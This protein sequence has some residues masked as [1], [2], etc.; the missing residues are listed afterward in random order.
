MIRQTEGP[1]GYP[2]IPRGW[3]AIAESDE[4]YPGALRVVRLFGGERIL[5]R[6]ES[7]RTGLVDAYCAHLGAHMG[8]GGKVRGETVVCP[9][10]GWRYEGSGRCVAIDYAKRIPRLAQVGAW[11]TAEQGG[12]IHAAYPGGVPDAELPRWPGLDDPDFRVIGGRSFPL[13]THTQELA[14]GTVDVAHFPYLHDSAR[15]DLKLR[16][17]GRVL[18]IGFDAK[19]MLRG[20]ELPRLPAMRIDMTVY[21]LGLV[22][23]HTRYPGL[24][25]V[26]VLQYTTP[27]AS[28]ELLVRHVYVAK[29]G[30]GARRLVRELLARV[31]TGFSIYEASRDW[32]VWNHKM[33]RARPVLCDGDGPIGPFRSWAAQFYGPATGEPATTDPAPES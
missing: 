4:L 21:G 27:I 23:I 11:Q 29:V 15:P 9:F 19:P 14:E 8:H 6:T 28:D 25:E 30:R 2:P 20:K 7:G 26:A 17:D 5:F 12:L 33:Y 22:V 1:R 3:Y 31:V 16:I 13:R 24:P 10:H 32:P 18:H